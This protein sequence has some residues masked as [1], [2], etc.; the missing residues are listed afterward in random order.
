VYYVLSFCFLLGILYV[1]YAVITA[2]LW[3]KEDDVIDSSTAPTALT[4]VILARDEESFIKE[5]LNSIRAC[6]YPQDLYE[7]ILMDDHST[8]RTVEI[9][10]SMQWPQL[11]ILELSDFDLS[12]WGHT[13]KKAGLYYAIQHARHTHILQMDADC[14]CASSWM[15][16]MQRHLQSAKI[17]IGPIDI[18]DQ[19][20]GFLETW[21]TYESIGTMVSTYVGHE[22][23]LW[24]SGASANMGYH[25]DVYQQYITNHDLQ[26]AS[27]DDIFMIQ[28]AKSKQQKISYVKSEGAL[29]TTAPVKSLKDLYR[30]RLRWASKT[31]S[32]DSMGLKVFMA[33]MAL[34]HVLLVIGLV[35][36]L[37]TLGT[38]WSGLILGSLLL[39]WLGDMIIIKPS[40]SFFGHG[41]NL[42]LSPL[43]SLSH[44]VY[45][46][47]I[48]ILATF[49]KNYEW[50][51]RQV[52]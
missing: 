36:F 2:Y 8:D 51:G 39:K 31:S 40:A 7:V 24:S 48:S 38:K 1:L 46:C 16:D 47:M 21:Q 43:M 45:V 28:D 19:S 22:L 14:T 18:S 29:V 41:Y 35:Y 11:K 3:Q 52:R 26:L 50:K 30:Q 27:G 17:A 34:F 5:A 10:Q 23:D 4:V 15:M 25:K 20:K 32:Y 9:A 42:L 13:Y 44:T 37:I 33:S 12:Q 6:H 49:K